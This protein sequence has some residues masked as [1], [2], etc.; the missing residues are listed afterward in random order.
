MKNETYIAIIIGTYSVISLF[1]QEH[2][3]QKT[4]HTEEVDQLRTERSKMLQSPA[5]LWMS[6]TASVILQVCKAC[7]YRFPFQM[8]FMTQWMWPMSQHFQI[9][10]T[11]DGFVSEFVVVGEERRE[12][13]SQCQAWWSQ[14]SASSGCW[15][16][17][18]TH[19]VCTQERSVNAQQAQSFDT[20]II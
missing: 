19:S 18:H 11:M 9:L 6:L 12:R 20:Q 14:C 2:G 4:K 7:S 16:A 1:G 15:T 3:A 10:S 5:S 8:S 13:C 17:A